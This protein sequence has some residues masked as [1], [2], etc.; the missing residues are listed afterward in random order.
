MDARQS[1]HAHVLMVVAAPETSVTGVQELLKDPQKLKQLLQ[2]N[3]NLAAILV[4]QQQAAG[5]QSK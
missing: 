5:Q 2:Q 4:K 1:V 3:P